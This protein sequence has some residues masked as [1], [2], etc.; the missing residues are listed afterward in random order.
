MLNPPVSKYNYF[1]SERAKA[2]QGMTV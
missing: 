2:V 1:V